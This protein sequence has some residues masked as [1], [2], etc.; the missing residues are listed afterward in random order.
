M[1]DW[2]IGKVE[3]WEIGKVEN[4]DGVAKRG[5]CK[6]GRRGVSSLEL[7]RSTT[8]R[9]RFEEQERGLVVGGS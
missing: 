2:E 3:D 5:G 4:G 6:A 7:G 8:R 9:L 1:E